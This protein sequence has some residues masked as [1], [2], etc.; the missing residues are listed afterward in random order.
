MRYHKRKK[1][2]SNS[3]QDITCSN[4]GGCQCGN[5]Q[6]RYLGHPTAIYI[7]HC[8]E[9]QKQ[10]SSAFGIS[11]IVLRQYF[12]LVTGTPDSWVKPTDCEKKLECLFCPKCGSRLWHQYYN[13]SETVSIKGGCLNTPIDISTATPYMN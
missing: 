1:K 8:R 11:V 13:E 12:E 4:Y 9:C 5:I 10:S 6:Y 7:C 2:M 3:Y